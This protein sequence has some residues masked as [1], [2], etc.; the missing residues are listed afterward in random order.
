MKTESVTQSQDGTTTVLSD[1]NV[2]ITIKQSL[3]SGY[4]VKLRQK[5]TTNDQ[6][7]SEIAA[8]IG[9]AGP[10]VTL[11]ATD[12]SVQ[13]SVIMTREGIELD[14]NTRLIN[15][16]TEQPG[17]SNRVWVDTNRNLKLS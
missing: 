10:Q 7:Y 13:S 2:E 5:S 17:Q 9:D 6:L 8:N 14:G 16:P 15:V 11:Q 1:D 12:G 4:S 3:E